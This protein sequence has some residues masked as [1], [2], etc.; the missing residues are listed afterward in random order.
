MTTEQRPA[1]PAKPAYR[2]ERI[3]ASLVMAWILCLTSYMIFQDKALSEASM[4][5][6]KILLSLSGAVML[7]TLPGFFD[8]NYGVGGLSIRAAGGAAAFVFIYT[9]SPHIPALKSTVAPIIPIESQRPRQSGSLGR[10]DGDSL[11]LLFA[12]SF[13]PMSVASSSAVTMVESGGTMAGGD[14]HGQH[15]S[16]SSPLSSVVQTVTSV[17]VRTTHGALALLDRSSTALRAAVAWLGQKAAYALD[18]LLPL[19]ALAISE[20]GG[21]L[22]ALPDLTGEIVD[23]AV[24]PALSAIGDL[25]IQLG[26][27]SPLLHV[28]GETVAVVPQLLNGTTTLVTGT[29]G[30]LTATVG[31]T[32]SSTVATAHGLAAGVLQSP[33]Q[34]VALTSEAVGDLSKGLADTTKD[35]L[36]TT[37]GLTQGVGEQIAAVT[38]KLN[39]VAP[40]LI[41]Q[42]NPDFERSARAAEKLH[43][44]AG[45]FRGGQGDFTAS[46]P[47]LPELRGK[48]LL[49]FDETHP[50]GNRSGERFNESAEIRGGCTNCLLQPLENTVSRVGGLLDTPLSR[51]GG[52]SRSAGGQAG[53]GAGTAGGGPAA[54][55]GPASAGAGPTGGGPVSSVVHSVG[56]TV[57]GATRGLLRRR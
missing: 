52:G 23:G 35:V 27:T 5:F 36:A 24:G 55:A 2:A 1:T 57:S 50:R 33:G 6:L 46:L 18:R 37:R 10:Y 54:A 25:S 45:L 39:D 41:A 14:P 13:D 20:F 11:P 43:E 22:T 47:A 21:T 17:I 15:A 32:L 48:G 31:D 44:G 19:E 26:E 12:L 42:I 4:Y 51:L 8:I 29:V 16:A 56:S 9:Q 34:A 40:A 49:G 30:N 3:I 38:H 28:V 7:A 53:T